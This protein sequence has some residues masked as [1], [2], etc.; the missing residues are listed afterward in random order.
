MHT[1]SKPNVLWRM[2]PY[3]MLRSGTLIRTDVSEEPSAS[4]IS[5]T[6]IGEL[7][8]GSPNS[9]RR[10][11]MRSKIED[12][13]VLHKCSSRF[14]HKDRFHQS[15]VSSHPPDDSLI[16][17][18]HGHK[19]VKWGGVDRMLQVYIGYGDKCKC[20]KGFSWSV[21]PSQNEK[22]TPL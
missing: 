3:G 16:T 19:R 8:Y 10:Y 1:Y 18:L 9:L 15:R 20:T 2:P 4:I 21:V 17:L 5:V 14:Q 13:K 7:V 11:H 6:R 12:P 22:K